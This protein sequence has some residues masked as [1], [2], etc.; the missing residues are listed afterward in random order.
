MTDL[1]VNALLFCLFFSEGVE[2]YVL[3]GIYGF[4]AEIIKKCPFLT[5]CLEYL[6]QCSPRLILNLF[7]FQIEILDMVP[8]K[9]KML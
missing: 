3:M 6:D 4:L 1:Q 8:K 2:I 7:P 5:F 9:K